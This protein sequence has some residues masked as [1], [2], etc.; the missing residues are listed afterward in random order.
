M[1]QEEI[2]QLRNEKTDLGREIQT[3]VEELATVRKAHVV[4]LEQVSAN[5]KEIK[6][7]RTEREQLQN[8]VTALKSDL[9]GRPTRE[10]VAKLKEKV[11]A[12]LH[13]ASTVFNLNS[14]S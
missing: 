12:E 9:N 5:E 1:L 14:C 8:D 2:E 3:T 13:I 11:K 6:A 4:A 10:E 7:L